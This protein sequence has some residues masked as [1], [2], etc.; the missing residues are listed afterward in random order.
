MMLPQVIHDDGVGLFFNF[1]N[2]SLKNSMNVS[3][4]LDFIQ[5]CIVQHPG[6]IGQSSDY[7]IGSPSIGANH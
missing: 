1:F 6:L 2:S 5:Y 7:S 4:V 3:V